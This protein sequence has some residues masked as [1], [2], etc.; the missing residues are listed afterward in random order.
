M[1]LRV[2]GASGGI[3]TGLRTTS[4]LIDE[5]LL[6][7]AGSGVGEL[8]LEEMSRIR[9]IFLTH[10]HLD[11]I[12]FIP[13]LVDSIFERIGTSITIYGLAETVE[14]L[15]KH[16]FNWIIWPDFSQLPSKE[17]PVITFKTIKPT[18]IFSIAGRH[19]EVIS[20]NHTVPAVGYRVQGDQ[21]AFA[22]TGDTTTNDSFWA[23]LNRHNGLDLLIVEAAF[24][25]RQ[26][27]IAQLAHHYCPASLANDL[28]KLK[29][30]P[31]VYLTHL[32][33]GEEIAI[34]AESR[35]AIQRFALKTLV[36]SEIFQL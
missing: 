21:G 35:A 6:I 3:G 33:P 10:S 13:L 9:H 23:A 34:L 30:S 32:K 20:V 28:S 11:H 19:I 14:A 7:D 25:N 12:A 16:I 26:S 31:E 5:D 36:G 17:K 29:H 27:R 2:L 15:Q 1:K 4:L 22:F 18:E 24:T 8:S